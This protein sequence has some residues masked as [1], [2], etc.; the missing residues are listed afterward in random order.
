MREK[1]STHRGKATYSKRFQIS[2]GVFA[3]VKGLRAGHRFLRVS[4]DRVREEWTE[5][6]IAHNLAKICGFTLCKLMEW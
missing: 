2:E 4:L 6:C 1:L 3:V 5:R